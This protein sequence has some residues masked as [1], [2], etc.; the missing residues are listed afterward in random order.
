M[1]NHKNGCQKCF[2]IGEYSNHKMSFP[3]LDAIRRSDESFRERSQPEHH[4]ENSVIEH[5]NGI[6]MIQDFPTSDP[7]H[8]LEL[9]V[10]RRCLYR[11]V[12][13]Q[14]G[15]KSKWPRALTGLASRLLI[16]CQKQIPSDIHRAVRS[17]DSLRHW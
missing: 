9:G 12:L 4:K 7:L 6:N 8:L 1:F 17:L 5:L 16:S 13:G 14:K 10:M 3:N 15:F 2:S 11:W